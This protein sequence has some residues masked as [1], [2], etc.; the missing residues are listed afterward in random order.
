MFPN[1][2]TPSHLYLT[3]PVIVAEGEISFFK[4]KERKKKNLTTVNHNPRHIDK[5]WPL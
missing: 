1:L 5:T 3:H 2:S 4:L